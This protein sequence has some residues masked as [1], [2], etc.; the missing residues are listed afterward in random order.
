[1]HYVSTLRSSDVEEQ[2]EVNSRQLGQ[3]HG[4]QNRTGGNTSGGWS[5]SS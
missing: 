2:A 1:M 4:I 3:G 5:A